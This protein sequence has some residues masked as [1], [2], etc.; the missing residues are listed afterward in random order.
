MS[1]VK[2]SDAIALYAFSTTASTTFEDSCPPEKRRR[3]EPKGAKDEK[4]G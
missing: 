3:R 1:F 2:S 4:R